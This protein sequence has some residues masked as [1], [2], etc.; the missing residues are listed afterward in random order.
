[1]L[2]SRV[3]AVV[4]VGHVGFSERAGVREHRFDRR[5]CT[6]ACFRRQA[7]DRVQIG[8]V[9]GQDQIKLAQVIQ[10]DLSSATGQLNASTVRSCLHAP[11]S[12]IADMPAPCAG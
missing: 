12:W 9:H 7:P 1:M 5:C 11:I 10:S 8:L 2:E 6:I 4:R 3:A